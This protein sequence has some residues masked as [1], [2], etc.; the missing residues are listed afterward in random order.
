M[1]G[2]NFGDKAKGMKDKVKGMAKEEMGRV[3][4][5]RRKKSEGMVERMQGEAKDEHGN[6]KKNLNSWEKKRKSD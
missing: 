6:Q 2:N 5:N 3:T 4:G 1:A